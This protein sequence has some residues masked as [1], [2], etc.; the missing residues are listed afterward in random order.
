MMANS[1]G[2]SIRFYDLTKKEQAILG[3][4]IATEKTT[5]ETK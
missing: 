3:Q 2:L 5:I 4:I 1:I